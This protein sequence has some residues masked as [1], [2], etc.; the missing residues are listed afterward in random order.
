MESERYCTRRYIGSRLFVLIKDK[1][2]TLCS[3]LPEAVNANIDS[4]LAFHS[5]NR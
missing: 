2:V 1:R 3:H 5:C 4:G